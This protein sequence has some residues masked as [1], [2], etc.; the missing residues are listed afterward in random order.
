M[1]YSMRSLKF[2][3]NWPVD[4]VPKLPGYR[5]A[6][7]PNGRVA[8]RR[9]WR[10]AVRDVYVRYNDGNASDGELSGSGPT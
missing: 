4:G 7:H 9:R 3:K 2:T 5:Q 8:M 1:P 6:V 10:L